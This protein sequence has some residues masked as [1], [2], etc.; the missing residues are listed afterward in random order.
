MHKKH[1]KDGLAVISVSFDV[2]DADDPKEAEKT[3]KDVLDFLKQKGATFTN[4]LLDEPA[5]FYN[6]KLRFTLFPS[7]YVFSRQGKWTH[8]KSDDGAKIDYDQMDRL[9]VQLLTE[10]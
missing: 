3:K 8:F 7:I 10:K 5:E 6:A 4:L 1:A 9:V 2:L